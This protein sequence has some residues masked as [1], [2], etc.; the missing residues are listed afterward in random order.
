MKTS[1]KGRR[2]SKLLYVFALILLSLSTV[3]YFV[4]ATRFDAV[5]RTT[6]KARCVSNGEYVVLQGS[7][8]GEAYV[9][10]EFVLNDTTFIP[11]GVKTTLNFYCRYFDENQA[12]I[13]A[14]N[15]S[16]NRAEEMAANLNF[17]RFREEKGNVPSFPALYE[18][19]VVGEEFQPNQILIPLMDSILG[20]AL[21]FI[22]L[23]IVRM[24]YLYVFF[25]KVVWHPFRGA[26]DEGAELTHKI[27]GE[28]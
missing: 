5:V 4:T 15:E 10:D 7:P 16:K 9:F 3:F 11:D 1:G 14:H 24:S 19:E 27:S 6:Y 21:V 22:L 18:L 12:H 13:A 26:G 28:N 25:G 20:A 17:W 2:F 23:Q 8:R